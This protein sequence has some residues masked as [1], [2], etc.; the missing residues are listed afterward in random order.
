MNSSRRTSAAKKSACKSASLDYDDPQPSF[1]QMLKRPK[2]FVALI[3]QPAALFIAGAMAGTLAKTISCPLDR[4]KILLQV[5]GGTQS[6][7]IAQAANSGNVVKTF[8]AIGQQEGLGGYFKGN[9]PQVCN[10]IYSMREGCLP[11]AVQRET[12]K[13]INV[14]HRSLL[15]RGDY[16]VA[17]RRGHVRCLKQWQQLAVTRVR[18]R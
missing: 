13:F 3:P 6:G 5:K 8:I 12:D 4:V 9:I 2:A 7:L 1:E 15:G 18:V 10:I 11:C 14:A 16:L 17:T